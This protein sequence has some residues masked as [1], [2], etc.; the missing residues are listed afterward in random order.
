M[1]AAIDVSG[2]KTLCRSM[3]SRVKFWPIVRDSIFPTL[4]SLYFGDWEVVITRLLFEYRIR[5]GPQSLR[6][7]L[8]ELEPEEAM[9]RSITA[10]SM[11]ASEKN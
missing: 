6:V 3:S 4:F 7:E 1:W 9:A 5:Q 10:G 2:W 11:I 8:D